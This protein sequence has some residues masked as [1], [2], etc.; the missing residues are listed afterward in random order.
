MSRGGRHTYAALSVL[1]AG[2][3]VLTGCSKGGSNAS[4]NEK[5]DQQNAKRQ[6]ASIK[7]GSAADY[8][9]DAG[10]S[11]SELDGLRPR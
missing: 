1:A 11:G 7:F 10:L 4:D 6:Q 5:K 3:L 9:R 2:A 8:L